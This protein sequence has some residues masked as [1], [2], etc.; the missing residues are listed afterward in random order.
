M[1][2]IIYIYKYYKSRVSGTIWLFEKK[3]PGDTSGHGD[4]CTALLFTNKMFLPGS[5]PYVIGKEI[6]FGVSGT[7]SKI[8]IF[9]LNPFPVSIGQYIIHD[10][11]DI[12]PYV[13]INATSLLFFLFVHLGRAQ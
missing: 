5:P 12:G 1:R 9:R 6:Q 11:T 7:R 8:E 13:P 3:W 4:G 10:Y 2:L